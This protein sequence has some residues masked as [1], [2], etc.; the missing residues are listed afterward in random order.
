MSYLIFPSPNFLCDTNASSMLSKHS[1]IRANLPP[2]KPFCFY[3]VLETGT[4]YFF[5]GTDLKPGSSCFSLQSSWNYK[6]APPQWALLD[7]LMT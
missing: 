2:P 1:A 7:L 4:P 3:I 6:P 5:V